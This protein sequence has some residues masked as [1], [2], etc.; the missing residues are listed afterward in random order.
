M[1]DWRKLQSTLLASRQHMAVIGQGTLIVDEEVDFEIARLNVSGVK[2]VEIS[3][4]H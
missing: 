2:P 3:D 1:A 4:D